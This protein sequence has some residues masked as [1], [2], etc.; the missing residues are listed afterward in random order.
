[1]TSAG[2]NLRRLLLVLL[3]LGSES[4][5]QGVKLGRGVVPCNDRRSN[6]ALHGARPRRARAAAPGRWCR[7]R[8]RHSLAEAVSRQVVMMLLLAHRRPAAAAAW[9]GRLPSSG[10]PRHERCCCRCRRCSLCR[11]ALVVAVLLLL[12]SQASMVHLT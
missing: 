9:V 2:G 11:G 4:R 6:R 8:G 10:S 3:W 5:A 12:H 1:Q 7:G